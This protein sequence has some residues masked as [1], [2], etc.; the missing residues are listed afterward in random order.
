MLISPLIPILCLLAGAFL[1]AVSALVRFRW[2]SLIMVVATGLAAAS[3][4]PLQRQLPVSVVALDWRP[5]TLV[6]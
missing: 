4:L 2:P 6:G 1:M 5:V 3:M